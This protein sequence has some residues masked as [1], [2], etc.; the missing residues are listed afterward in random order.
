MRDEYLRDK[1]MPVSFKEL[2]LAF[3]LSYLKSLRSLRRF[4]PGR[5][6]N[7]N[8][9]YPLFLMFP[10]VFPSSHRRWGLYKADM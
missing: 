1:Q 4:G 6:S 7:V 9:T 3:G 10:D 5:R 2:Q 8:M